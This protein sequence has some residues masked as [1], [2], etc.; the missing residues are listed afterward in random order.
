M[1]E[2]RRDVRT[3]LVIMSARL[4]ELSNLPPSDVTFAC[5]QGCADAARVL[6]STLEWILTPD[7]KP[8]IL[9]TRDSRGAAD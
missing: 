2:L 6:R 1:G 7:E 8:H 4:D 5:A 9:D 3:E